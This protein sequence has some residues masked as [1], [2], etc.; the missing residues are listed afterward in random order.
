[1]HDPK[2]M[3]NV[4][5]AIIDIVET[6]ISTMPSIMPLLISTSKCMVFSV[7]CLI[8]KKILIIGDVVIKEIYVSIVSSFLHL[9]ANFINPSKYFHSLKIFMMF[10]M[11]VKEISPFM[12]YIQILI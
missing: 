7:M 2:F 3:N 11:G 4:N 8:K 1:M 6:P 9:L 10:S 12:K 5:E